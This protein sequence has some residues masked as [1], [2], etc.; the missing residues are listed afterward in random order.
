VLRRIDGGAVGVWLL[1]GGLVLY[2]ALEGGGYDIVIR[3]QVGLVVWWLVLLGALVGLLPAVRLTRTAWI[4]LAVFT[5]FAAWTAIGISWSLSSERSL[6]DVSLLVSYLGVL[7]LGVGLHRDRERALRHTLGALASAIVLVAILAL[8][9]RLRPGLIPA[10]SQ[11][12]AFLQGTQ[13]RLNWPL[14]YWNALGALLAFGL[15]LLL[16]IGTCAR[17]LRV[18]AAA[19][20]SIPVVALCGYL[21]FSR[22]G[23]LAAAVAVIAFLALAPDRFSKLA[24]TAVAAAGGAALIAAAAHRTAI[25]HGL[26]GT[27]ARHQGATLVIPIVLVVV[28]VALAQVGIG[29]AARH[30]TSPR[31]LVVP[32]RR[33]Q[34]LLAAGV[35]VAVLA[36][37]I[38]GVPGRISHAWQDF[39][40]PTATALHD[41]SL[42]RFGTASG[43]GRY[44]Y[45]K[46]AV[47]YSGHH[48]ATGSGPGTFQLV[49]LPRA[50]YYSY[51]QNAHSLYVETL[52]ELGIPGLALL[53][54]FLAVVLFAAIRLVVRSRHESRVYAAGAAGALIAFLVSAGFDWVWQ[55]PA[56]PIAFLLVAAAL[57]APGR[58]W[59][60]DPGPASAEAQA[61]WSPGTA[62]FR[63]GGVA[64]AVASLVA[65]AV[66]LAATNAV[67]AS[68]TAAAASNLTLAQSEAR[69]AARLE[70]G[71]ASAN[72]QLAL[73]DEAAGQYPAALAAARKAT[74]NEPDNWANWLILSRIEAEDSQATAAVAAYQRARS[75]NPRSPVFTSHV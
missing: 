46:I 67:R 52:A 24:S 27:V 55:V 9:S 72:L 62:A 22:G 56:L 11:T 35:A 42:G 71:A 16:A 61:G 32:R 40:H 29:L 50:S 44:D 13:D 2:L 8:I 65:I 39:K 75:L 53:V 26:T 57:L 66:P 18:Q 38:A 12:S 20:S 15:P 64:A 74:R 49:W 60:I 69:R 21:T 45:W 54:G 48:L 36:C 19:L 51:I 63:V 23:A 31:L 33:A 10:A 47:N 70:P 68:Q 28:G 30:G 34:V 7:A 1:A 6:A 4:A 59:R 41:Y 43:N 17:S 73:V 25:E 58:R 37:L 3:S 5:A 14:N